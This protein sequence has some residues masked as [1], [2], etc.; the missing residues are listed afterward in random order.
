[1][2]IA[3]LF[4]VFGRDFS[5]PG[6]LA[7]A[8]GVSLLC[9][10][11]MSGITG[12]GFLGEALIVSLYGFGPEALPIITMLGMLVD[13]PAT[14]INSS[15]DTVAAMIVSRLAGGNQISQ[16]HRIKEVGS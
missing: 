6:T 13:A 5:G 4:S 10:V 7:G 9:G 3:I 2:K 11:V 16:E 15:G 12:G 14:M 8:I 1:M